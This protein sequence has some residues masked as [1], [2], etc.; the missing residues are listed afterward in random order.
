MTS[1][2]TDQTEAELQSRFEAAIRT[3]LPL[4][5]VEFKLERFLHLK[6]G[7]HEIGIDGLK[8][9]DT[10]RGRYDMLLVSGGQ[11]LLL[12]ELKAPDVTITEDDVRQALSYARLHP[13]PVPLVLVTNGSAGELRRGYDGTKLDPSDVG[14]ERLGNVLAKSAA[15][16]LE[17]AADAVRTLLSS[18]RETWTQILAKWTDEA[19]DERTGNASDFRR[20]IVRGFSIRRD[21]VTKADAKLREGASVVVVHAPPLA[22]VTNALAQ[23]ARENSTGPRLFLDIRAG[24]D[25]LQSIANRLAR[26]LHIGVTKDDLRRWFNVARGMVKIT[27][28]IDGLP[29]DELDELLEWAKSGHLQLVLGMDSETRRKALSLPGRNQETPLGRMETPLELGPLSDAEFEAAE[30]LYFDVF[31]AGFMNGAQRTSHL[32][33]VRRHR[34]IAALLPPKSAAPPGS[35]AVMPAF[36]SPEVLAHCA[37]IFLTDPQL[38]TDFQEIAK[39]YLKEA[40]DRSG[41]VNWITGSWGLPS[42]DPAAARRQLGQERIDALGQQGLLSWAA[43]Q[44]LGPRLMIRVDEV[45]AHFIAKKWADDLLGL[46]KPK[47]IQRKLGRLLAIAGVI[48]EGDMAL[49]AALHRAGKQRQ[50]VMGTAI[51]YLLAQRPSVSRLKEGAHVQVLAKG[52]DIRLHFG[53]GMDEEVMGN[54]FPWAVLSRCLFW[55]MVRDGRDTTVNLALFAEIG[56]AQ[57]PLMPITHTRIQDMKP[58]PFHE[59]E[60]VGSFPCFEVGIL[61]PIV[62]AMIFHGH[63]YPDEF[64]QL[65]RHSL[66]SA[67]IHL[68]RRVH[69][70]ARAMQG[71]QHGATAA[72]ANAVEQEIH[73]WWCDMLKRHI[74]IPPDVDLTQSN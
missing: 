33:S 15:L 13:T 44:A 4:L 27:L 16:A 49:A 9:L 8:P 53:K 14:Q 28:V 55:T 40:E 66:D 46:A 62:Q 68:S 10:V 18:S 70:A 29:G 48:P 17:A 39:I 35:V 56:A 21:L 32:R 72:M 41:E 57:M 6:L 7:H 38:Q 36:E 71:S 26:E 30:H 50:D 2:V 47:A 25:V 20:P 67:D 51:T 63:Q 73:T 23:I 54:V 22:G 37:S 11:A 64:R 45:F 61:E 60:G 43:T 59:L 24:K 69:L 12:I 34:V 5:S 31:A 19:I 74:G 52:Q 58:L 3:V 42:V 1:P 65:A